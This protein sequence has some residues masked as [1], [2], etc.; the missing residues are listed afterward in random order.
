MKGL[1][2]QVMGVILIALVGYLGN[3]YY[4]KKQVLPVKAV[5]VK[6]G[7]IVETVS[8]TA[9]GT[10]ES[11]QEVTISAEVSGRIEKLYVKEGDYIEGGKPL[12]HLEKSE[13]QAQVQQARAN[14]LA[15][16]ARLKEA[17]TGYQMSKALIQPQLDE[18]KAN[19]QHAEGT[20][21]RIRKLYV[22]GIMPK[23]RLDEAERAYTIARAQYETALANKSQVRAKE[24]EVASA[25]AAR[26]QM[27]AALTLAEIGLSRKV[28]MAPFSG[29]ITEV[30]V[31]QGE[32]I[33]PGQPIAR[34]VDTSKL[35]ISATID[36]ADVRKVKVGQE[37]RV[38][39]DAFPNKTFQGVVSEISPVISAK[40]LETRTSKVK[41][42]LN[43]EM[44]G[45]MPGLS[46]DIEIIVGKGQNVL[47]VPTAAI[48]ERETKK[49]VFT[50]EK[51]KAQRREVRTGLSNWDY[52]EILDGLKEGEQIITTLDDPALKE[53]KSIIL[54]P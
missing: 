27:K 30:S 48:M 14:L 31:K 50:I 47:Y 28:I 24:Q 12:L 53:G 13:A 26:E 23:D 4:Q 15:A 37:V 7:D 33:T 5:T 44:E 10:I 43:S 19:L 38:T 1:V 54:S 45:L 52:T 39:L 40:K 20:L 22:Q 42:R 6:R 29:L 2:K 35:Y 11:D 49:M 16:E 34:I 32:F 41:V 3:D 21:N 25:Y 9:T 36:E 8:S 18:A 46:A 17:Q 51:G